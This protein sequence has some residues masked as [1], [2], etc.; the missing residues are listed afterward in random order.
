MKPTIGRIVIYR[1][2]AEDKDVMRVTGMQNV[3]AQLPAIVVNVWSDT[4]INV[5]VILDGHGLDLW[6]SSINKGEGDGNWSW[7]VIER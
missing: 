5:K 3:V 7:P 6:K 2:T 1:T 4:C